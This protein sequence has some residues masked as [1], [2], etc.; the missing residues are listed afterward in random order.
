[1]ASS[2]VTGWFAS[3]PHLIG[4]SAALIFGG[5]AM[6][7]VL[8]TMMR[9][10]FRFWPLVVLAAYLLGSLV[11]GLLMWLTAARPRPP[12]WTYWVIDVPIWRLGG[13]PRRLL[14][15]AAVTL[16]VV[17]LL[18]IPLFYLGWQHLEGW[19]GPASVIVAVASLVV[20]YVES[21]NRRGPG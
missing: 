10:H 12:L 2:K 13:E 1:M 20:A 18:Y 21:R 4:A 5:A 14:L 19:S 16:G 15:M 11:T 3:M 8:E 6:L 7:G 9:P 17:S